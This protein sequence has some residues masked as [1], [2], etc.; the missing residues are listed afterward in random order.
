MQKLGLPE[1]TGKSSGGWRIRSAEICLLDRQLLA[2]NICVGRR[3]L[4]FGMDAEGS[5][6]AHCFTLLCIDS[7]MMLEKRADSFGRGSL[8][9]IHRLCLRH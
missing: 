4:G 6:E 2:P 1:A 8:C 3:G 7:D 9:L 5:F